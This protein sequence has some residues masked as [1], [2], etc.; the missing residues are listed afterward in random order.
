[1]FTFRLDS[2]ITVASGK[3]AAEDFGAYIFFSVKGKT[4]VRQCE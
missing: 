4:T 1:M 2:T 3:T